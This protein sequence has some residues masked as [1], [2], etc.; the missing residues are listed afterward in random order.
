MKKESADIR[1]TRLAR[2]QAH[3][4]DH[5]AEYAERS[6]KWKEEHPERVKAWRSNSKAYVREWNRKRRIGLLGPF[7]ETDGPDWQE[8]NREHYLQQ[9]RDNTN[10]RRQEIFLEALQY[11]SNG[12]PRCYCCG[13]MIIKLLCLD[14]VNGGGNAHQRQENWTRL[15]EWAKKNGWPKMFR[16]ACHSCNVGAHLNGGTCPHQS[17]GG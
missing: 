5:K 2:Y 15:Y 3:Y 13:E 12:I 1:S 17:T 14:H 16:I 10:R 4:Q 11:Y 8:L 9:K 7:S 6:S